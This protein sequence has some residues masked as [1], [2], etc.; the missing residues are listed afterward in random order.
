S[1]LAKANFQVNPD[2]CSIAVQEIDFLS[3][4]INEQCIKPN[5]DKI[6]AI[7]D[8][9]TP[10]T[11]KEANEFLG[12]INWYRK[13]IPNFARI[14]APLHK[15]TNKTKHH[16]HEFKWGPDQQQS[17]D[18]FKRLLT[19][20]PLFLEYPDLSTPFVLT[21]DASNIGIGGILRQD[22]PNGTKINY[23]KS[24]MLD[25]TERKYDTIEQEALAIFW[26]ISELRS[27]IGDSDF[28]IETDHKPLE[29]F[30]KK[31]INNKRVMNWLFKL[32]DML[33]QIIAV[34]HRPGAHNA[35]ADYISRHFPPATSTNIYPSSTAV[36]YDDWPIEHTCTRNGSINAEI[37]AVTTRAQSKLQAQPHSSSPN[38]SSTSTTSQSTCSSPPITTPLHDFSLSR[39]R[40][41][42]AQD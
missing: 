14:A 31:Q 17:F 10:K 34:K 21:T 9:P 15:V 5:G 37:N 33:P 23:F 19:T 29:N 35:A 2:K 3:H 13:F 12:K 25:D 39:I 32:Q 11:L 18:E 6:K 36:T 22:T 1:I 24:R 16:R 41:E 40:S 20:Y 38:A 28:I 26:C 7:V 8:L 4:T 27:Y 30:H 42:Q